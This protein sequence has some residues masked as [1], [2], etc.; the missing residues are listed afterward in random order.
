MTMIINMTAVADPTA[1]GID[2]NKKS[3]ANPP[4]LPVSAKIA[5]L[6]CLRSSTIK[7]AQMRVIENT[8]ANKR[9]I[10]VWIQ[11][12]VNIVNLSPAVAGSMLK[13]Q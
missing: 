12:F 10:G 11:M 4:K 6:R 2:L 8:N 3:V 7:S 5:H 13:S 9:R 1:I